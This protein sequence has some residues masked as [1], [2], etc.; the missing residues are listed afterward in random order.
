MLWLGGMSYISPLASRVGGEGGGAINSPYHYTTWLREGG[1][2]G[3]CV[4]SPWVSIIHKNRWMKTIS[5]VVISLQTSSPLIWVGS[6]RSWVP[7]R[8]RKSRTH[9]LMTKQLSSKHG[10]IFIFLAG[11][12]LASISW[13]WRGVQMWR[14]CRGPFLT[15]VLPAEEYNKD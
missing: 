6:S 14:S 3:C 5:N 4:P 11:K 2:E 7:D 10:G 9:Q 1:K 12:C 8:Q 15:W 13:K